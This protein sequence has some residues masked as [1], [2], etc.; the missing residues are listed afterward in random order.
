MKSFHGEFSKNLGYT[1]HI[2]MTENQEVKILLTP[3]PEHLF[4][5]LNQQVFKIPLIA[6]ILSL[7]NS[8]CKQ[9]GEWIYIKAPASVSSDHELVFKKDSDSE[10]HQLNCKKCGKILVQCLEKTYIL[11]STNWETLSEFWNC[12]PSHEQVYSLNKTGRNC[13]VSLFYLHFNL[14]NVPN[15]L[16]IDG[17]KLLCPGCL[18]HVGI[19]AEEC[20]V[21]RHRVIY[22]VEESLEFLLKEAFIE[23]INELNRDVHVAGITI[24]LLNWDLWVYRKGRFIRAMKVLFCKSAT[25]GAELP[26][27]DV[28]GF[29]EILQKCNRKLPENC[30]KFGSWKISF[31]L[32][33]QEN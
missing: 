13:Y 31:L 6:P 33:N 20:S 5:Q 30:R 26:P 15:E 7:E 16:Q 14:K 23:R 19:A 9:E 21:F 32:F 29:K 28:A 1:F 25:P 24:R 12:H 17:N 27:E 11:P 3:T 8:V 4:I 18:F 2:Q 10:I 22:D